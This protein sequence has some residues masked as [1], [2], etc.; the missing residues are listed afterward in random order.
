MNFG[1][2]PTATGVTVRG[3]TSE[4]L[5]TWTDLTNIAVPPAHSYAVPVSGKVRQWMR[6]KV[7]MP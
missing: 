2:S 3:Q 4:D 1:V 6:V 7:T 5:K